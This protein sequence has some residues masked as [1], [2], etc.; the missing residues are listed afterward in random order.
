MIEIRAVQL[1][2]KEFWYSLDRHLPKQEFVNK[3]DNKRGY[4]ITRIWYA[5]DIYTS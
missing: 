3:V 2:D 4:E 5:F 1:E